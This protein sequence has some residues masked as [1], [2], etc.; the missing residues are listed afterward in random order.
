[1]RRE[2]LRRACPLFDLEEMQDGLAP[3]REHPA[4]QPSI[5]HEGPMEGYREE[6]LRHPETVPPFVES[7]LHEFEHRRCDQQE[8]RP[9]NPLLA[10]INRRNPKTPVQIR[11]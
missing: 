2:F 8:E 6:L 4:R 3:D 11:A 1:M 9:G 7:D 5:D 10:A